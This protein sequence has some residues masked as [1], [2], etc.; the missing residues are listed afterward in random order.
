[1]KR[2]TLAYVFGDT[3]FI[4]TTQDDVYGVGVVNGTEDET[5]YTV[6][7]SLIIVPQLCGLKI[8]GN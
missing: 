1:M 4:V 8:K 7:K 2:A 3:G 5:I 6:D